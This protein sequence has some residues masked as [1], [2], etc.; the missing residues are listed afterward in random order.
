MMLMVLAKYV[1]PVL[2]APKPKMTSEEMWRLFQTN[3]KALW[4]KG[5]WDDEPDYLEFQTRFG[6]RAVIKR[7]EAYGHLC[8]YVEVK[9]G[10]I[11]HGAHYME[12]VDDEDD[13]NPFEL[14]ARGRYLQ[15]IGVHGRLT[16]SQPG[17]VF[18]TDD[19]SD[20]SG[21]WFGF[22][23]NHSFDSNPVGVGTKN[24]ILGGTDVESYRTMQYVRLQCEELAEG[25]FQAEAAL[26]TR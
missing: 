1:A 21:W 16:F 26:A 7:M 13:D 12:C 11:L 20:K 2:V 6:Y 24:F 25:L 15:G 22:D 9:P 23:C 3:P 10:H 19:N 8:G 14:T 4:G 5:P 17:D 18:R